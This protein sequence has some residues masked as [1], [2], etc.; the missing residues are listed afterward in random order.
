MG[1]VERDREDLMAEATALRHRAEFTSAPQNCAEF[2]SPGDGESVIVGFRSSGGMSV[3]FGPDPCYHF[4]AAGRLRRAFV[5]GQLYRT[6]GT[7]LAQLQRH[8]TEG[9]TTL[10]RHDLDQTALDDFLQHCRQRLQQFA[11]GLE[12]GVSVCCHS[13]PESTDVVSEVIHGLRQVLQAPLT[14]APAIAGKR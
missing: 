10:Q 13:V 12:H 7:T 3:Y 9:T 6:Q 5:D 4:D 1:R 8:R 2:S 14:L 11:E